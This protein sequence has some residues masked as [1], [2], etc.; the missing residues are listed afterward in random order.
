MIHK[1]NVDQ[2]DGLSDLYYDLRHR[3]QKSG[4]S[5]HLRRGI[6]PPF[7]GGFFMNRR[8]EQDGGHCSPINLQPTR[9]YLI[10]SY[11]KQEFEGSGCH[12]K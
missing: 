4:V 3:I 10:F 9:P 11:F 12:L 5:Y 2:E 1:A 6:L 8:R 7:D